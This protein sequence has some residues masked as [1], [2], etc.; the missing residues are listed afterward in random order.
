MGDISPVIRMTGVRVV[1]A[2]DGAVPAKTARLR[3]DAWRNRTGIV[4]AACEVFIELGAHAPLDEIARRAGVGNATLYRHFRDRDAL[5]YAVV[6]SVMTHVAD[7][8]QRAADEESDAFV[9]LTR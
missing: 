5:L 2:T 7:E 6:L 9:A 4:D 3:A 1:T 8:A